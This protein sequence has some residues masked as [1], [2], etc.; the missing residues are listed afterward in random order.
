VTLKDVMAS[1]R[2]PAGSRLE[3]DYRGQHH[4]A[5]LLADGHIRLAGETHRTLSSAG[6]AVKRAVLGPD[7]PKSVYSTDGWVFWRATDARAG[8]T[9][10][11]RV[12]R[13]RVAGD[14]TA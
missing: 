2:L 7:I 4:T 3:A 14:D 9:T 10:T 11:L 5:E 12:I 6:V 1:G 13:Q 8:D